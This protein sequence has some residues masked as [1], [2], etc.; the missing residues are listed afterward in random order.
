VAFGEAGTAGSSLH[1]QLPSGE[2]HIGALH[3]AQR[4]TIGEII[5]LGER[6]NN[7]SVGAI[8]CQGGERMLS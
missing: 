4:V 2:Q 7:K 5:L 8:P 3:C 1:Q 6:G